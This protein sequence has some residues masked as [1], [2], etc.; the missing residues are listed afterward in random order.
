MSK[1]CTNPV[2]I[3]S[4][5]L[6]YVSFAEQKHPHFTTDAIRAASKILEE[7][8]EIV[9]AVND[10]DEC[11]DETRKGR[12]QG[13]ILTECYQTIAVTTRMIENIEYLLRPLNEGCISSVA[14]RKDEPIVST[15]SVPLDVAVKTLSLL[16]G[17]P[18][19]NSET[20]FELKTI[21]TAEAERVGRRATK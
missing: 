16:E 10:Y 9:Q 5:A 3:L 8:G 4:Q 14:S 15:I 7:A 1:Q 18:E 2:G 21:I 13:K 6:K 17:T 11:T 12:L 20:F 19:V